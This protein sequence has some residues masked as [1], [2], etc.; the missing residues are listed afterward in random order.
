MDAYIASESG[1]ATLQ[2]CGV[3]SLVPLETA[4][5]RLAENDINI[6]VII[7]VALFN[8]TDSSSGNTYL[9]D[10]RGSLVD[11]EENS[12][13]Y[14]FQLD[15][16]TGNYKNPVMNQLPFPV[17]AWG[18]LKIGDWTHGQTTVVTVNGIAY[19]FTPVDDAYTLTP[20]AGTYKG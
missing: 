20:A 9:V 8:R 5:Q 13:P 12:Q 17:Q 14:A 18:L 4:I 6:T 11:L 16:Q 19:T 7:P 10:S 3:S 2:G 15:S 1:K